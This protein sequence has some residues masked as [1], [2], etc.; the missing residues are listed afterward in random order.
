MRAAA[1]LAVR[2][3]GFKTLSVAF[4]VLSASSPTRARPE[5]P[6]SRVSGLR[7]GRGAPLAAT[8]LRVLKP[9]RVTSTRPVP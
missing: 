1:S 6:L 3:T 8:R 7:R 5:K 2:T 9:L 4:R